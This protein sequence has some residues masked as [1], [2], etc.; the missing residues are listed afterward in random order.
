MARIFLIGGTGTISS[1]TAAALVRDGHQVALFH[2]SDG[3][4]LGVEY[5]GDRNNGGALSDAL[6]DFAA[7]I[8]VDFCCYSREQLRVVTAALPRT[9]VQFVFV[10]TCDVFGYP[11]AQ[12]PIPEEAPFVPTVSPYATEKLACEAM[13]LEWAD[14]S[15]VAAT[16]VRPTYTLGERTLI[17][18]LDRSAADL[19]HRIARGLEVV[20]P[21]DGLGTIHPSDC[22]DTG[23]MIGVV[24]GNRRAFGESFT[25][26]SD[27][28]WMTH[29]D[30]VTLIADAVGQSPKLI[31]VEPDFLLNDTRVPP[32]NLYREVT[33]FDLAFGFDKFQRTFPSFQWN[34]DLSSRVASYTGRVLKLPAPATE[35][36]TEQKVLDAWRSR[37]CSS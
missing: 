27:R 9:V 23:R 7:E 22:S 16:I 6:V 32:N 4:G 29:L 1:Q 26:G 15:P 5:R 20:L 17:S 8:V 24:A 36:S 12:V 11:L 18:L 33:G 34:T 28:S 13:L 21:G 37:W 10:S 30:Y 14:T 19:V 3:S 25:V 2:R 31:R 35:D